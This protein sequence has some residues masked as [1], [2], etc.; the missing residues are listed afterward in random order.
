MKYKK[1]LW[2]AAAVWMLAAGILYS[3]TKGNTEAAAKTLAGSE[4]AAGMESDAGQAQPGLGAR[5]EGVQEQKTASE[6]GSGKE[7]GMSL[8]GAAAPEE[9]GEPTIMVHVCGQVNHPGVYEAPEGSRLFELLEL[10]GGVTK[11]AAED[12]LNLA[13]VAKDGQQI[14]VPGRAEA[15][16]MPRQQAGEEARAAKININTAGPDQLATLRG[17]GEAKARDI[18]NYREIHGAFQKIEDIMK[19]SGIKEAA[20]EKIKD[21][22]TVTD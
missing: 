5:P 10:A 8:S 6:G 22:I 17:I 19:I 7:Q 16:S 3:C 18:I 12:Y 2:A 20:F 1:L 13:A 9:S 14:Y 4:T 21:Q 11:E 15:A